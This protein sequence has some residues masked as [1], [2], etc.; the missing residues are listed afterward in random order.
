M[1]IVLGRH[2]P[3]A[4]P[5]VAGKGMVETERNG[6]H[7]LDESGR[8]AGYDRIMGNISWLLIALVSLSIKLME[9]AERSAMV[10]AISCFA[11]FAYNVAARYLILRGTSSRGKTFVDLMIFLCFIVAVSRITGGVD[12]PFIP[13]I[14]LV[15][16]AASLTQGRRA[17]YFMAGLAVSSYVILSLPDRAGIVAT[18]ASL[19]EYLLHLFSFVLT[20]HL[21]AMLSGEAEH[22]RR[23]I[24][25]L[26]L[27]DEV[28]GLSNM[29]NFFHLA[30]IQEKLAMRYHRPFTICMLDADNLKKIND[31]HGH[32]AGTDL[33]RHTARMIGQS[34]RCTDIVARYGGDEFV[35]MYVEAGKHDIEAAVQRLIVQMRE[36]PFEYAGKRLTATL[37]AGIASYPDDGVDVA[38]VMTRADEAMY[39]SKRA[40]KNMVTVYRAEPENGGSGE[41][42]GGV[43]LRTGESSGTC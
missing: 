19:A 8:Y 7:P 36:T 2:F 9:P 20:A 27:A 16:M 17:T 21:G 10:L 18:H 1:E 39:A 26:S 38:D 33:I 14:Y 31:V 43:S 29:R 34:I 37:S 15:L 4:P 30:D 13:L 35:V 22:A 5:A 11:L 6:R 25:K 24:E 3:P 42:R 23:E 41:K 28:T 32:L 40:G 12:S